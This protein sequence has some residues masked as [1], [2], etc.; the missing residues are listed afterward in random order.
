LEAALLNGTRTI[1]VSPLPPV[2]PLIRER[3]AREFDDRGPDACMVEVADDLRRNNPE[4]LDMAAKCANSLGDYRRIMVGFGMFYRLLLAP[5]SPG[6][7]RSRLSPLPRVT[8]Q[9]REMIVRLIDDKGAETFTIDVIAE[10]EANNPELL[11]MAHGFASRQT[12]YLSVMQ[13]F[14]LLYKSLIDQLRADRTL[15]H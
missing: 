15:L 1:A 6:D 8:P 3:I 13:G 11:Q 5:A 2:T 14:A 9:T 10:L 12:E 7:E 4:L